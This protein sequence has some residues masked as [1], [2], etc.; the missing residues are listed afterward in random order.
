MGARP[1]TE[2]KEA[3]GRITT[4]LNSRVYSSLWGVGSWLWWRYG[5]EEDEGVAMSSSRV[6]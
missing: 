4:A 5:E 1:E 3:M 2:L 6:C